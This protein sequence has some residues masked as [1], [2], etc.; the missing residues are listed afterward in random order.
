MRDGRVNHSLRTRATRR[1]WDL[2]HLFGPESGKATV[3]KKILGL[4]LFSL[5]ALSS[6]ACQEELAY[7]DPNAVIVAAPQEIWPDLQD[8]V[9]AVL[10]PDV[11]TLRNERTFRLQYEDPA[12]PDW[13]LK[14]K[15]KEE[16]LI[17]SADD[18]FMATAL[19][20]LPDS[21]DVKAPGVYQTDNVWARNQHVIMLLVDPAGEIPKQVLSR[22]GDVHA[23]LEER[24]RAGARNRMF[25]SGVNETLEDSL[26]EMAGFTLLLPNV[27]RW[28]VEDSLYIFRNDNPDP[29]ELIRQIA[30]TWLSPIPS[31][32]TADSLIT[33]KEAASEEFYTYP[34]VV[35]PESVRTRSLTLDGNSVFEVRGAWANPPD[36]MWPAA[37]PFIIWAVTCPPQ[38]R[39]YLIDAWLYAPGKDKWEYIIQL[40]TIMG[41]FRCGPF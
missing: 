39:M 9:F 15:F 32:I 22:V 2:G 36:S 7:G 3:M 5:L 34:Q 23:I 21:V 40:E 1:H 18:P 26:A 25:V 19:A 30:V 38:D 4:T 41:S 14:R 12:G 24:F 13:V 20:T 17:G 8:S 31:G 6:T 33:W 11:Y 37:G 16:V 35:E 28:G 10:S 29:S 27:Y